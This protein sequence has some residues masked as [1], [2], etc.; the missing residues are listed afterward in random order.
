QWAWRRSTSGSHDDLAEDLTVKEEPHGLRG[1]G[2]RENTVDDRRDAAALDLD[3]ES[4]EVGPGPAIGADDVDLAAPD[5]ADVRLRIES[6]S[7]SAGQQASMSRE[8]AEARHPCLAARVVDEH[9]YAS[10]LGNLPC[11]L[12]E[13]VLR[14][15]DDVVG[16]ELRQSTKL[17]GR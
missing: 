16:A 6:G 9:V 15:V 2:E 17:F 8:R 12:R 13:I 11:P 10:P 3:Q 1:V 5:V 7:C 4:F 14:V